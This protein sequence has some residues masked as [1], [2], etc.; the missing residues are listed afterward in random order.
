MNLNASVAPQPAFGHPL[1]APLVSI[2]VSA[3][4]VSPPCEGGAGGGGHGATE[5]RAFKG[6]LTGV[7]SPRSSHL[8]ENVGG[9]RSACHHPPEPPLRKG[10]TFFAPSRFV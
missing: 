2:H 3:T 9:V 5:Y 4:Q 1:F 10:G 8:R 7:A 6:I